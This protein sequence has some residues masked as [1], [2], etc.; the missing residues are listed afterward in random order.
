[1][2]FTRKISFKSTEVQEIMASVN[3]YV[4]IAVDVKRAMISGGD[5]AIGDSKME[6]LWTGS[7]IYDVYGIGLDLST[8]E[9]DYYSSIN[10]KQAVPG[11]TKE[12]PMEKR[13]RIETL[14]NYFFEELPVFKNS[15]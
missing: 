5:E 12:V 4:W 2:R 1:M 11:S 6:L 13:E 10:A 7:K 15:R 8:G 9:I 14:I 3:D